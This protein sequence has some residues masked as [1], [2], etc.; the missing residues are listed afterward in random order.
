MSLDV[1]TMIEAGRYVVDVLMED[2]AL[3]TAIYRETVL[4]GWILCG[5]GRSRQSTSHRHEAPRRCSMRSFED[6]LRV[7]WGRGYG[8]VALKDQVRW[9]RRRW[10]W[11]I[12]SALTLRRSSSY[13]LSP[14]P[15]RT[16]NHHHRQ[17]RIAQQ[18]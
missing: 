15:Q 18:V 2:L 16:R 14:Y 12:G 3:A 11:R 7:P 17:S 4:R 10:C 6:K 8:A 1:A 9:G 13:N 5:R